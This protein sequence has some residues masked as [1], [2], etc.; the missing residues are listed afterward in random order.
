MMIRD[1]LPSFMI[2]IVVDIVH[3]NP[4]PI[5]TSRQ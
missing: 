1:L 3:S 4:L 5:L 2:I